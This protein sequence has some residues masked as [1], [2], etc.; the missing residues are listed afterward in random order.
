MYLEQQQIHWYSGLY[1]QPQHLQSLD[2]HHEWLQTQQ[3]S[4]AQPY[5]Y[6]VLTWELNQEALTDFIVNIETMRFVMPGGNY[7]VFPG[8]CQ[9]EKRNFRDAWKQRDQPFTLWL[10][11]RRLDPSHN[12]VSVLAR[13]NDRVTTRW[14][15]AGDEVIMKDIYDNGPEAAVPHICYN[16][17][18][19][20]DIERDDA[21]DCECI[22]LAR[23]RFENDGVVLDSRYSPPALTLYSTPMLGRVVDAIYFEL[24]NRASKLEEYKRPERLVSDNE[25]S[26]QMMQLLVMRSLN[27][28]L[29]LLHSYCQAR[30]IHPWQMYC[31]LRQLVGDLSSFNDE[32]SFLGEWRHGGNTVLDYDHQ[33]L[34]PCFES[35]RQTLVAL[36]NSLVLEDNIYITLEN[37]QSGIFS[38]EFDVNQSRQ[39]DSILL[40]LRS[41]EFVESK[42]LAENSRNIKL[43]SRQNIESL[44]QHA[45]PGV[46]TNLCA[47]VP[48][49]V[50]NRSDSYYFSVKRDGELWQKIEQ[51]KSVAFYWADA[52]EDLQVQIIFMVAS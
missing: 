5:N 49:G 24:S 45:L 16:V 30:Q 10:A 42:L 50:P 51:H 28:T 35:L 3:L 18:V 43:A 11:L 6:G 15:T 34:I 36:L 23:L 47:Q 39:S 17:R 33:Q 4:M 13:D 46:G 31:V 26:D 19:L 14:I 38:T 44:I 8:N 1:L 41:R 7:L 2:L 12:N 27:R 21:V 22:P 32:C 9:I 20:W 48:R 29:P 52:P 25:R 37:D 40:L